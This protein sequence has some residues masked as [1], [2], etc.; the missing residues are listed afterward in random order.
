MI[1]MIKFSDENIFIERWSNPKVKMFIDNLN[2][3]EYGTSV[4]VLAEVFHKLTKKS[5]QNAFEYVRNLMGALKMFAVTQD[6]LFSAMKNNTNINVNDKIHLATMKRN[7]I[8]TIISLDTDFDK[9]KTITR[10]EVH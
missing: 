2:R 6:D 8:Y 4:L 1:S 9:D 5:L 7:E 3:E 10:E